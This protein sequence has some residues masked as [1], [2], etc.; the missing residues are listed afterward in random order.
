MLHFFCSETGPLK[1]FFLSFFLV[2]TSCSGQNLIH[3]LDEV[4]IQVKSL[5]DLL[6]AEGPD[7]PETDA[8][9]F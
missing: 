9:N 1:I 6:H 7:T 2:E 3:S 5:L 4:I 8:G